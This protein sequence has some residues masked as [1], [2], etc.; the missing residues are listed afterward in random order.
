MVLAAAASLGG[1]AIHPDTA[2]PPSTVDYV[3]VAG[4]AGLRWD[5]LDP[6]RTP[7]LWQEATQ[8]SIGWLSVRSAQRVTC[9]ADGWLTLGAGNYA[10]WPP[11]V[12]AS[13][14][15]L[16]PPAVT[17]PDAIGANVAAQRTAVRREP[18]PAAVRRGARRAGRVG[19]VH[20]R[21]RPGRGA[22]GGPAVRA[23]R[24]VRAAAARRPRRACSPTA[25]S[26]SSTW[27]RS[28][29][30]GAGRRGGRGRAAD[31]TLARV[32]AARP[33]RSLLLVAG[34]S[35]TDRTSRLHVAI[36]E[37]PGLGRRLA[38][39]GRHRP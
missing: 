31:A 19:A 14:C 25:C 37:G 30:S 32:L 24:Q 20:D 35:D 5:D 1:L 38:H 16:T 39:L 28:P 34:V 12:S 13:T 9:P 15:S 18:G 8:G 21:V 7:A 22:R 23:G 27:A 2:A 26:A 33:Q 10:A 36:A 3:I 11:L 4:A 6:Q 17:Q 29:A